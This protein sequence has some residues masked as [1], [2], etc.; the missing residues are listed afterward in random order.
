ML[1]CPTQGGYGVVNVSVWWKMWDSRGSCWR[2]LCRR[3]LCHIIWQICSDIWRNLLPPSSGLKSFVCS[4][5]ESNMFWTVATYLPSCILS[6]HR[7]H[8]SSWFSDIRQWDTHCICNTYFCLP[9]GLRPVYICIYIYVFIYWYLCASVVGLWDFNVRCTD[10]FI[11]R[12]ERVKFC[13]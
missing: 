1:A 11:S 13:C 2:L 7:R 12:S 5:D 3:M 9:V 4:E 6:H 10:L 8:Y